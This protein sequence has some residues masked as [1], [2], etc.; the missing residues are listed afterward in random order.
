M[1][2]QPIY[3]HR[4]QALTASQ[5]ESGDGTL[6]EG[7]RPA[8]YKTIQP[9]M[10]DMN[11]RSICAN[12]ETRVLFAHIRAASGTAIATVNNHPFVF[13][14]HGKLTSCSVRIES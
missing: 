6:K 5:G 9:P 8:L 3:R 4:N 2:I 12:T 14:R 11:F 1:S 7:L 13:G 10:N